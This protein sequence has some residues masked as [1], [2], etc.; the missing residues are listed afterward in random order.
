MIR[1]FLA[2]DEPLAREN[3]AKILSEDSELQ[4]AGSASNG[5]DALAQIHRLKPDAVFL[6]IEMPG[7]N[8]LEVAAELSEMEKPPL[9][10]FITAYNLY[11]VQAFEADAVDYLLKP[12]DAA[13]VQ[14]TLER[15]KARLCTGA[16]GPERLRSLTDNLIK[17]GLLKK[18][19]VRR[20]NAKDRLLI[21]PS[22]VLYFH[23]RLSEVIAFWGTEELI[24]NSTL[25]ELTAQLN[26]QE[27]VQTHKAYLVNVAKV[28]KISPMF[29]GNFEITLNAPSKPVLPLSR[30][31][32]KHLKSLLSQW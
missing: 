26:P 24:V 9:V 11:A 8:G 27:F 19:A 5:I 29:S 4:I 30:R 15:V 18:I 1:L 32:A 22:E 6:D 23:A 14:K 13:R 2:D 20:R 12:A 21:E 10:I 31:Y 16:S 7:K 28:A 25:K 17:K 3:L